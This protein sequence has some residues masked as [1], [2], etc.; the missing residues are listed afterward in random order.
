MDLEALRILTQSQ[1]ANALRKNSVALTATLKTLS[2]PP[3][4]G[5]RWGLFMLGLSAACIIEGWIAFDIEAEGRSPCKEL[6]DEFLNFCG[7]AIER[8]WFCDHEGLNSLMDK[9][10]ILERQRLIED[11]W[12]ADS[13][14]HSYLFRY[15]EFAFGTPSNTVEGVT[16][17]ILPTTPEG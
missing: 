11:G 17:S 2:D 5:A 9:V 1:D 3:N 15:R 4:E 10:L 13:A 8:R 12:P 7:S 16:I 6:V 14:N